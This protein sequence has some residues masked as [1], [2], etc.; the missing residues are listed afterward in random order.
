MTK[1]KLTAPFSGSY[2]SIEFCS[3]FAPSAVGFADSGSHEGSYVLSTT[4]TETCIVVC[5]D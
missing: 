3:F 5:S 2:Y 4:T 1:I